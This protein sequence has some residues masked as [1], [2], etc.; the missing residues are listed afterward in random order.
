MCL[1]PL[2]CLL[3]KVERGED[4]SFEFITLIV[5]IILMILL[6]AFA[7]IVR[8]AQMPVWTA[9]SECAHAAI[10]SLTEST[11]RDQ[12]TQAALDS[13]YGNAIDPASVQIVITGDW[14]PNSTITCKV[15]YNIDVHNLAFISELT[16]GYVPISAQVKLRIE[17][18]KSKW[19]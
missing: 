11:S 18:Y 13:L 3:R 4:S 10:F 5:P 1:A 12:A 9:A 8:A 14:T 19:Q 2:L 6:V 15:S 17:P 16:G 7:T